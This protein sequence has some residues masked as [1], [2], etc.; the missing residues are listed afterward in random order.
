M[1]EKIPWPVKIA[2]KVVLSRLPVEGSFWRRMNIFKP[3]FMD[4]PEYALNVFKS[5]YERFASAPRNGTA[6]FSGC[7][8]GPGDSIC[9]ALVAQA[10]GAGSIYLVDAQPCASTN[11]AVWKNMAEYLAA[12]GLKTPDIPPDA[13]FDDVLRACHASYKTAG[14]ASLKEIPDKSVDFVWSQAVLE[15]VKAADFLPTMKELR[16]IMKKDAVGSHRVDLRD[17]LSNALNNLRFK[18][19]TWESDFMSSSG[20][21]TNRI[22]YSEMLSLFKEAGFSVEVLKVD[23]W[24]SMPTPRG[25]MAPPFRSLPVEELLISGFDVVLRPLS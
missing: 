23:R 24:E 2:A 4:E 3:G 15:H 9:S 21:Y 13:S 19:K 25:A 20:F 1:K 6:G 11:A 8:L 17:H 12:K 10:F 18:E 22:R 5:H 14:L 7:E 16:R